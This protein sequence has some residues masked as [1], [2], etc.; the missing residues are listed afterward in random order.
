MFLSTKQI[1]FNKYVD[2]YYIPDLSYYINYNLISLLW[3]SDDEI[4][5]FKLSAI[6]EMK[7]LIN[8][9]S[10]MTIKD[11]KFLLYENTKII[12]NSSFFI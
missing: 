9:H 4:K 1:K 10:N 8:K 11:A 6:N 2:I 12:Y 3:Y 7:E 5:N